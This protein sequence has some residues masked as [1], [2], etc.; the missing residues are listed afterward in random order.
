M[1]DEENPP[2]PACSLCDESAEHDAC[3]DGSTAHFLCDSCFCG[4]ASSQFDATGAFQGIRKSSD[5]IVSGRGELPCYLFL[6][7]ECD[8]A[9]IAATTLARVLS[10]DPDALESYESAKRRI[11]RAE[12][13]EERDDADDPQEE[14]AAVTRLAKLHLVVVDALSRG[15]YVSCPRCGQ[16]GQKNDACMHMRCAS[17]RTRY[18]YCCGRERGDTI[19][20]C[21]S[22]GTGCDYPSPYLENHP[23]WN[24]FSVNGETAGMG[25]LYEFHRRRMAYFLLQ[26]KANFPSKRWNKLRQKYPNL[27]KDVPT[28]G[29]S[30]EWDEIDAAEP[31]LFGPTTIEQL[32]WRDGGVLACAQGGVDHDAEVG[33]MTC[34]PQR[35]RQGREQARGVIPAVFENQQVFVV[36]WLVGLALAIILLSSRAASDSD[37][38]RIVGNLLVALLAGT[39]LPTGAMKIVD[40]FADNPDHEC[41]GVLCF[42]GRNNEPPYLAVGGRWHRLRF[43]YWYLLFGGV[44]LASVCVS[45]KHVNFIRG[46]GAYLLTDILV[47][48][49]GIIVLANA[50]ELRFRQPLPSAFKW[51]LVRFCVFV[52]IFS[53]G[54]GIL[55]AYG[56]SYNANVTGKVLF[57]L[58]LA[59]AVAEFLA[60]L[61]HVESRGVEPFNYFYP[62]QL[63]MNYFSLVGVSLGSLMVGLSNVDRVTSAGSK[64]TIFAC[65]FSIVSCCMLCKRPNGNN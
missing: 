65:I 9:S 32:K 46:F 35:Q 21:R 15:S 64:L 40:Y 18:C 5:D 48:Y 16:H 41:C 53:I 57:A 8:C 14:S 28:V 63:M 51:C 61:F 20:T 34:F 27:L 42:R 39:G 4:Y 19:S 52:A 31:P 58:G 12:Q 7:N 29:R 33:L 30:I 36:S 13:D 10:T 44:A 62:F 45:A 43:L 24:G 6:T 17:C 50:V 22:D 25:A 49:S 26:V 47:S 56:D 38:L 3:C 1:S 60:A 55:V 2:T 59:G 37:A 11:I 23:G 54:I